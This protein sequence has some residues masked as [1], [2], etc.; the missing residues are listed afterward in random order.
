MFSLK[1]PSAQE[2]LYNMVHYSMVSDTKGLINGPQNIL[3]KQEY[4]DYIEYAHLF[5]WI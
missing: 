4:I 1:I 2:L 5:I 3:S